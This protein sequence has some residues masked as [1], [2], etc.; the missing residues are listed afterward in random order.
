MLD[1]L[2]ALQAILEEAANP[3]RYVLT[4][5][6]LQQKAAGL[7]AVLGAQGIE[8][9]RELLT[10]AQKQR[11]R[12]DAANEIR[13]LNGEVKDWLACGIWPRV[14]AECAPTHRQ[15]KVIAG[16]VAKKLNDAGF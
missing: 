7:R 5:T 16:R 14:A 15:D 10:A 9:L 1:D 4:Q 11:T 6:P 12:T 13:E 2:N 8:T 3:S